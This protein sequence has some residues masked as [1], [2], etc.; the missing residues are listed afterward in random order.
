MAHSLRYLMK[1]WHQFQLS[2]QFSQTIYRR[3]LYRLKLV[4]N[5]HP[6]ICTNHRLVALRKCSPLPRF[7]WEMRVSKL[8]TLFVFF[9]CSRAWC[10][11]LTTF[12]FEFKHLWHVAPFE[13]HFLQKAKKHE[14]NQVLEI[15]E[16]FQIKDGKKLCVNS[17]WIF[18]HLTEAFRQIFFFYLYVF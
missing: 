9:T 15:V 3:W 4:A 10:A 17:K 14:T 8:S 2:W 6:A 1:W 16:S 11:C 7:D 5:N 12:L 18:C 13:F